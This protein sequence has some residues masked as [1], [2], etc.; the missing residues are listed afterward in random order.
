MRMRML[1]TKATGDKNDGGEIEF[2][3]LV[4]LTDQLARS[5]T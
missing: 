4:V 2:I 5:K 3:V 1:R